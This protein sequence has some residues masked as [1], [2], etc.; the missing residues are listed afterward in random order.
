MSKLSQLQ[1]KPKVFKIGE[2]ELEI[3]PLSL[4]DMELFTL[5]DKSSQKEQ[6]ENSI[7]LINK[8]LRDSVP[9]AT[10]EEI[11]NI[12]FIYMTELMDAITEVNGLKKDKVSPLDVIKARQ[13]QAK[14]IG[15]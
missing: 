4:K 10:E 2:I 6:T 15:Q 3:K 7:K 1:G 12:G 14:G 9:D 13:A 5:D 8:V 11:K